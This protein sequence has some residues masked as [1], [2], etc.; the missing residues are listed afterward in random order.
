[1]A[2]IKRTDSTVTQTL[3]DEDAIFFS[4]NTQSATSKPK[5]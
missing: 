4:L 5:T 3:P 1:M 2:M